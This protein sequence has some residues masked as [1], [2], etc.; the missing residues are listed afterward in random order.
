MFRSVKGGRWSNP[1]GPDGKFQAVLFGDFRVDQDGISVWGGPADLA[2]RILASRLQEMG[3]ITLLEI[4]EDVLDE[5]SIPV[6][7]SRGRAPDPAST[8]SHNNI[9]C[10]SGPL[11]SGLLDRLSQ[12][13]TLHTYIP[14]RVRELL[15]ESL[16]VGSRLEDFGTLV[17]GDLMRTGTVARSACLRV[18]GQHFERDP[19]VIK[20]FGFDDVDRFIEANILGRD[21][22]RVFHPNI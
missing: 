10:F 21:V 15:I 22:A 5:W 18:L 9:E 8:D 19:R 2:A 3:T 4:S 7:A 14:Q 12:T 13:P 16:E 11:L 17:I 1:I 20:K 6:K